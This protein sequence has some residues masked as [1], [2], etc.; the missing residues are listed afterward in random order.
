M[1]LFKFR[2][3]KTMSSEALKFDQPLSA[4]YAEAYRTLAA[5]VMHRADRLQAKSILVTSA[6][7]KEGKTATAIHLAMA[8]ARVGKKVLLMD[9]NAYSPQIGNCLAL[10]GDQPGL[11][12]WLTEGGYDWD[13]YIAEKNALWIMPFGTE[14]NSG[15]GAVKMQAMLS[16]LSKEFD[17]I[18]IDGPSIGAYADASTLAQAA[19]AVL[20]VVKQY[21]A[22]REEVISA[23]QRLDI[24][25]AEMLGT[26]MTQFDIMENKNIREQ[27]RRAFD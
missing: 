17:Y 14:A 16:A 11:S 21:G 27:Y 20:W 15:I 6:I 2:N 13:Q 8:M 25:G 10:P 24:L 19:D 3:N 5:G 7:A 18:L 4:I 22:N 12:N 26:V 9:G 23:R 1:E